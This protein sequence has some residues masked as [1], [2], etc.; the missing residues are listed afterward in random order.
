M[1]I[2]LFILL[3]V[4]LGAAAPVWAQDAAESAAVDEAPFDA[5]TLRED[6]QI[7]AFVGRKVFV[8]KVKNQPSRIDHWQPERYETR[9]E[10][11][12]LVSGEYVNKT[13]D[14]YID[15][16]DPPLEFPKDKT[17]LIIIID[18]PVTRWN[19]ISEKE[20][21]RTTDGDWASCGNAYVHYDPDEEDE[22][23]E[24]LEPISFLEPVTVNVPSF[25]RKATDYFDED[26]VVTD[27]DRSEA[28]TKIDNLYKKDSWFIKP[29]IWK[30]E[31]PFATCQLGMRARDMYEFEY[32]TEILPRKRKKICE[33]RHEDELEALG[34]DF[35][36]KTTLLDDCKT[37]L[38]IQNLP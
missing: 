20:V 29:P 28:K 8:R 18:G 32:Q 5:S 27:T 19:Y 1:R 24:P 3:S 38:K 34:D 12:T 16:V 23:K 31:G 26:E 37:L 7:I 9:Y 25:K 33:A 22:Y 15:S 21:H 17:V 6:G 11:L 30:R 13:I 36:A 4:V 10:I 35:D 2:F 14:F